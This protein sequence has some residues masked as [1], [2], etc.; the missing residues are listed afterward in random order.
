MSV[1]IYIAVMAGVTYAIR[2]LPLALIR[3]DIKSRRVRAFLHYVP[4]ATLSAMTFPAVLS[5]ADHPASGI[6][7]L[8]A[9]T[10]LAW[11]GQS[12]LRV[13]LSASAA[14]YICEVILS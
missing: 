7:A 6:C 8:A 2:V 5:A 1:W 13:A 14:I 11:I 9:S 12:P 4:Y 10:A 3:R